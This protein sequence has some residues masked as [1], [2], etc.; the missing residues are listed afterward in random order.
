MTVGEGSAIRAA[1]REWFGLDRGCASVLLVLFQSGETPIN[2]RDLARQA[3]TTAGTIWGYVRRLRQVLESEAIDFEPGEG[4][5][6]TDTGLAE[7]KAVLR[8]AADELGALA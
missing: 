5:R 4:Y 1:F 8:R 7:C 2:K 6:L 3:D